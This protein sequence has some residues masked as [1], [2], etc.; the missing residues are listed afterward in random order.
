MG[1]KARLD[2]IICIQSCYIVDKYISLDQKTYNPAVPHKACLTLG[3]R[4]TFVP[5]FN[6]QIPDHY[7]NFATFDELKDRGLHR[8]CLQVY[9]KNNTHLIQPLTNLNI[10]RLHRSR[11]GHRQP[12]NK[13]RYKAKESSHSRYKLES[14]PA[15]AVTVNPTTADTANYITRLDHIQTSYPI[16]HS[17][18]I[19]FTPQ[20]QT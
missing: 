15:T 16:I 19:S 20:F 5:V 7:Y 13:S 6:D 14:T 10:H 17:D 2:S 3:K 11:R 9:K 12:D 8:K 1:E 18:L 4:A